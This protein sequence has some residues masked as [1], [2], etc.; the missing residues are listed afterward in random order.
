LLPNNYKFKVYYQGGS[1]QKTQ[2]IGTDPDVVFET[3]LVTMNLFSSGGASLMSDDAKY[4]ASGWK[5]FG[6]GNTSTS[7]ELLPNNYKFKVYYAGG[8]NQKSQSVLDGSVVDFATINVTM[9]LEVDGIP[10][11][12]TD[13]KCYASGWKTF[14]TGI[15][16]TSMELLPNTYKFKVY[17]DGTS[18]QKSQD[19]STNPLVEFGVSTSG[20]RLANLRKETE[21][22]GRNIDIS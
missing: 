13:A 3:G 8:T 16:E 14:G 12:S 18:E 10:Q 5:T 1:K 19:I 6:S 11:A 15:T 2:D 4:Y 7:M 21:N 20:A 17:F 9:T 22:Y